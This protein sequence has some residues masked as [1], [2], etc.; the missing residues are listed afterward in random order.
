LG[1]GKRDWGGQGGEISIQ[2]TIDQSGRELRHDTKEGFQ[3]RKRGVQGI[4]VGISKQRRI[5]K[6]VG[7]CSSVYRANRVYVVLIKDCV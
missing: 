7:T 1:R 6:R 3:V 4:A 2:L 5:I